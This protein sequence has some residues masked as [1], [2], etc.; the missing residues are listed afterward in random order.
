MASFWDLVGASLFSF[1]INIP[2]ALNY[3]QALNPTPV[4]G[5]TALFGVCGMLG[6]VLRL[7]LVEYLKSL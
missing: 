6:L 2:I 3:I 1:L 5:Y 7:D 4:H